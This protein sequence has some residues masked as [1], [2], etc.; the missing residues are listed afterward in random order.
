MNPFAMSTNA[1]VRI[2]FAGKY[3]TEHSSATG[4]RAICSFCGEQTCIWFRIVGTA[5]VCGECAINAGEDLDAV[6][7]FERLAAN[8]QESS[9]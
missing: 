7:E 9:K 8:V 4:P 1:N 5:I 6:A 2:L 3:A